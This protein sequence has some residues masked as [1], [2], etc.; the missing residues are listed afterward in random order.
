MKNLL[1]KCLIFLFTSITIG[2]VTNE[3]KPKSWKLLLESNTSKILPK[4]DLEKVK[5]EDKINDTKYDKPWRFG[6]MHSVD[7]G[8]QDGTWNTLKNGD[9][10]WRIAI[11]SPG[12]LSLN[13]IFDEFYLPKGAS[14]YLYSDDKKDLLGAYTSIQNQESGILGTWLVKGEKV[15]IEYFEP[16]AVQGEGKLHIAKATHGYRGSAEFDSEKALNDSGDCNLDVNCSIGDD[17]ES[18]K[19]H[20]KKSVG[21]LLSGGSGFCSGALIN[22]TSNDG[23][24]YFLTANHCFSDPSAWSFRFGWISPNSVCATT[25]ASSNGPTDMTISGA[26]LRARSEGSDFC[27]VEINSEI[28][29]EWDRVWAGWDKSDNF[30]EFQVGIHHPS[31]DVMKVCRDDNPA[32]KEI[33]AGAETWEITGADNGWELGVTEPGSSG[34]P[35]FD[36][37]GKIIGQLFGGGAACSGTVDNDDLDYYGRFGISWATGTTPE[38]RLSDW[39]DPTGSDIN[40]QDSFPSFEVLDLD[41]RVSIS[42]S[43]LTCGETTASPTISLRNLGVNDITEATITWSA[44][45]GSEQTIE[46]SG[47]LTQNEVV[48]F[49]LDPITFS[50]GSNIIEATLISVNNGT[51]ENDTNDSLSYEL[52]IEETEEYITETITLELLTDDYAEETTWEF[53][54]IDGTIVS[55]F[56]PYQEDTD[57]NTTFTY[58]FDVDVDQCYIFEIFDSAGDGICCNFGEGAYSL[59]T[60]DGT[61]IIDS[62]EFGSNELT[63]ISISD[64]LS[65][66]DF[67]TNQ[68]LIYPNPAENIVNIIMDNQTQTTNY[69]IYNILGQKMKI[70]VLNSGSNQLYIQDLPKGI[71][72]IKMSND[73]INIIATSKIIKN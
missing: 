25:D 52:N 45:G 32:T 73:E 22:N 14:V 47:T 2:Q 61:V 4:F 37:N 62:G 28:P 27:L 10:I 19:D 59:S 44:N 26:T 24:P 8:L 42:V 55:S 29:A 63:E 46:F 66:N 69:I 70:G 6:F 60:D 39:L 5:A 9:R 18:L 68:F 34:S 57:D 58:D 31:G 48:Q 36:Q 54:N 67:N 53:R 11:E 43:N 1:L 30:P 7:Y 20:N 13:F 12:A 72:F 38:T 71:Y 15:W 21:I 41:A 40:I 16:K 33:N 23:I 64:V 50:T 17:W 65:T 35:L 49:E 3:G 51:D 56:G